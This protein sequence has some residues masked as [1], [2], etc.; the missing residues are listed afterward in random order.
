ML[1]KN[2]YFFENKTP[3]LASSEVVRHYTG[4]VLVKI[5]THDKARCRK[6]ITTTA[7]R[8]SFTIEGRILSS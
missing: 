8:V 2:V 4:P 1:L 3:S 6:N 5:V 7:L